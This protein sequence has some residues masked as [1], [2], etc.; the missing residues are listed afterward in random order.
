MKTFKQTVAKPGSY[1]HFH[2]LA[3][4]AIHHYEHAEQAEDE[5]H[6]HKAETRRRKAEHAIDK[7]HHHYGEEA[8]T[9]VSETDWI[10]SGDHKALSA[11]THKIYHETKGDHVKN[12]GKFKPQKRDGDTVAKPEVG[13]S[14][15]PNSYHATEYHG[16]VKHK[17]ESEKGKGIF[18]PGRI[19]DV[20]SAHG[21]VLHHDA[22]ERESYT[23]HS[24]YG[25]MNSGY[26]KADTTFKR[27]L[28]KAPRAKL[29]AHIAKE[30]PHLDN[31]DVAAFTDAVHGRL[32]GK[33]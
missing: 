30:N 17:K 28:E 16:M 32:R 26:A 11:E 18:E 33:H 14:G 29:A 7:I 1:D 31:A 12:P 6:D 27:H 24:F 3:H 5:G 20:P 25:K 13:G 2:S 23:G 21:H 9:A 19:K 15:W 4:E 22:S 10:K 8:A